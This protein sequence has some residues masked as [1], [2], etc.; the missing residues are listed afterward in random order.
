[1]KMNSSIFLI[2]IFLFASCK[3]EGC[4]D[5]LALNYDNEATQDNGN[6]NYQSERFVGLYSITDNLYGGMIPDEWISERT[7]TIEIKQDYNNNSQLVIINWANLRSNTADPNE[8][9]IQV[10]AAVEENSFMIANQDILNTDDYK[11]RAS[12]GEL[13]GDSINFNFEYS[14]FFGEIFWGNGNGIR[15]E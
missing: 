4:T 12:Q 3:K 7:Y 13:I 1:M 15:I 8:N 6:C 5:L 10:F 11:A 14:N 9:L 2:L